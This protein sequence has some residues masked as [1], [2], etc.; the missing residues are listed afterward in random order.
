MYTKRKKNIVLFWPLKNGLLQLAHVMD[1]LV[2]STQSA[3]LKGRH[4]VYGVVVINEVV[5]LAK[6]N[7]KSCMIFKV[8][9]EKA[10]DSVE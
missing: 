1:G 5:D 9:F 10:Y 7:G 6:R 3:F 2:A 4:L 8:D